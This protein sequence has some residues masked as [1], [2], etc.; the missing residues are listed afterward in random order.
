MFQ[1]GQTRNNAIRKELAEPFQSVSTNSCRQCAS[2]PK[3]L[4][5]RKPKLFYR[6]RS[7]TVLDVFLA[8]PVHDVHVACKIAVGT[9]QCVA[10]IVDVGGFGTDTVQFQH[11]DMPARIQVGQAT[12]FYVEPPVIKAVNRQRDVAE[13][14]V[15][16]LVYQVV[17]AV[18]Q[19][20]PAMV[21]NVFQGFYLAIGQYLLHLP[22]QPLAEFFQLK[23]GSV[24]LP[25]QFLNR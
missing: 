3:V 18:K 16:S 9:Q 7:R 11:P 21:S 12:D 15:Q 2:L 19:G 17:A 14:L 6:Y 22:A 5:Y 24:A 13:Y 23:P 1:K 4:L 8:N 10:R 20:S 25:H